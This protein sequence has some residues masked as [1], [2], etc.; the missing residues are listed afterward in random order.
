MYGEYQNHYDFWQYKQA[1][2]HEDIDP[3]EAMK[4]SCF[5]LLFYAVAFALL[6]LVFGLCSGCK[7]VEYVPVIEH[8][9]DTLIQ[10]KLQKDSIYM[11]DSV[12]VSQKGDT[13]WVDRWHIK[14]VNH[15]EH[16]TTYISKRD[17]VPV[18]YPVTEYV[19]KELSWWQ[20]TRLIVINLMLI[21]LGVWLFWKYLL[22]MILKLT[23]H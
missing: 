21:S 19:E 23:K 3:D 10:T 4:S 1:E 16:D 6:L 11:H 13:V 20:K 18:P 5:V 12:T 7:S 15:L 22:P 14:C 9:T 17:S 8:K 2:N